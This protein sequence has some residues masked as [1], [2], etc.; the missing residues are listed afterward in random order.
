MT[1]ENIYWI[2]IIECDNGSFYTGYTDDMVKRYRLHRSGKGGAKYTRSFKPVRIAQCWKLAAGKGTAMKIE[3]FIK[4]RERKEKEK[5]VT[6]PG[7]L[8]TLFR[9]ETGTS[10][11][12]NPYDPEK[13]E[14]KVTDAGSNKKTG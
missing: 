9:S 10:I 13:I 2:Y 12:I 3:K 14:N 4:S 8:E 6:N 7:L 1:A 5:I 11:E